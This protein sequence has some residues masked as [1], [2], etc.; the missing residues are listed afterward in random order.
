MPAQPTAAASSVSPSVNADQARREANLER[1]Q[2]I[3]Q[4]AMTGTLPRE[5]ELKSWEPEKLSSAAI[6]AILDHTSGM[7]AQEAA[8]KNGFDVVYLRLLLRHP[9]AVY[10]R[11]T[12]LGLVGEKLTDPLE[13]AKL[14]AGDAFNVKLELMRTAKSEQVRDKAASDVLAIAGYG[15]RGTNININSNNK[16][17]LQLPKEVGLAIANAI[18]IAQSEDHTDYSKF[19]VA[20]KQGDEII[21]EHKQLSDGLPADPGQIVPESG[22]SPIPSPTSESSP[23]LEEALAEEKAWQQENKSQKRRIA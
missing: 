21:A 19:V 8:D 4:Q 11:A 6:S 20:G 15:S 5:R 12:I 13:R 1:L 3:I 9:D 18:K 10:L 2:A 16:S 7:T 23:E 17:S 14:A 22:A